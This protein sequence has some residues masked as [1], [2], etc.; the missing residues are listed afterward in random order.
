[1]EPLPDV[2]VKK[3]RSRV[4]R[5][6]YGTGITLALLAGLEVAFATLAD[7]A[8]NPAWKAAAQALSLGIGAFIAAMRG[9]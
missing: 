3:P 2:P 4:R 7:G 8:L 5:A 1:M 6:V 9:S